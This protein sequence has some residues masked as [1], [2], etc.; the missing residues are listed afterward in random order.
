MR[1]LAIALNANDITVE[2]WAGWILTSCTVPTDSYPVRLDIL[3]DA[4]AP[5]ERISYLLPSGAANFT[6]NFFTP[7]EHNLAQHL[8]EHG[9]LVIGVTPREDALPSATDPATAAMGLSQHS[10]DLARVVKAVDAVLRLPF[11]VIGHSGGAATALDFAAKDASARLDRIVVLD[12]VGPYTDPALIADAKGSV[13]AFQAALAAGR[14]GLDGVTGI[15]ALYDRPQQEPT[16]APRPGGHPGNFTAGGQLHHHL[17]RTAH[18]GLPFRLV[19][20]ESHLAGRYTFAENPAEDTWELDHTPAARYGQ[21][22]RAYG[23]GVIPFA[24]IRDTAAIWCGDTSVHHL[25]FANIRT[26]VL[27]FNTAKGMGD[28]PN[29]AG[30]IRAGGNPHVTYRVIEGYGHHDPTLGANASQDIWPL[31]TTR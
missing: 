29:G 5:P 10:A 22:L 31:L 27:W 3:A 20:H 28:H 30:L 13:A 18:L 26:K 7:R 17:I 24:F 19:Y 9:S 4:T 8:R 14:L 1:E 16:E 21:A 15:L 25:D 6:G 23:S 11:E 12:N 2:A